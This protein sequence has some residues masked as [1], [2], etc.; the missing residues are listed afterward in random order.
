MRVIPHKAE[1][2][3]AGECEYG[4]VFGRICRIGLLG[5]VGLN[6]EVEHKQKQANRDHGHE[7]VHPRVVHHFGGNYLAFGW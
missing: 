5:H 1:A 7:I 4:A 3:R 2:N 6:V